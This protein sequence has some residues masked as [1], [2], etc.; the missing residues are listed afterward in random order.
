MSKDKEKPLTKSE[1]DLEIKRQ[2]EALQQTD[3]VASLVIKGIKEK[4]AILKTMKV[5]VSD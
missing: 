5:T 1:I 3:P 4:I 2:F